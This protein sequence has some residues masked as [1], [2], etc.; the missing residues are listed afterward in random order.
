[1]WK[2]PGKAKVIGWRLW[3][4]RCLIC[5]GK[6]CRYYATRL[7]TWLRVSEL[8]SE[9]GF[10]TRRTLLLQVTRWD[11]NLQI[12]HLADLDMLYLASFSPGTVYMLQCS[13]DPACDC[14]NKDG[15][16][17]SGDP[18]LECQQVVTVFTLSD[19]RNLCSGSRTP[20]EVDSRNAIQD[21]IKTIAFLLP[22]TPKYKFISIPPQV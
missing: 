13:E 10:E 8:C 12:W 15:A 20:Q 4:L 17:Y 14:V 18:L 5:M 7:T 19:S 3:L 11:S 21:G 16:S 22:K 2:C 6:N 9:A 1:M